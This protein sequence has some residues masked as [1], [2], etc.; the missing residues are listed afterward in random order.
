MPQIWG[1][2]LLLLATRTSSL[3]KGCQRDAQGLCQRTGGHIQLI[4]EWADRAHREGLPK[5]ETFMLPLEGAG[6]PEQTQ[7]EGHS[8]WRNSL[9]KGMVACLAQEMSSCQATCRASAAW[10]RKWCSFQST[11]CSKRAKWGATPQISPKQH[12]N[13]CRRQPVKGRTSCRFELL[14]KPHA[15]VSPLKKA[16]PPRMW[17][18]T[19]GLKVQQS[20]DTTCMLKPFVKIERE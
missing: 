18:I 10:T 5:S 8:R 13:W 9:C 1:S 15:S 19:Q 7:W 16:L 12:G 6:F 14:L 4:W 17:L 11:L 3:G 20:R 2:S